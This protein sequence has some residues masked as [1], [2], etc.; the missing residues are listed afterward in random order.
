MTSSPPVDLQ[1]VAEQRKRARPTLSL[2]GRAL[3]F[4]ARREHSRAE[5]RR[6]LLVDDVSAA[7][8]DAVLDDLEAKRLLSDRRYA[9]VIAH[10]RGARYGVASLARTLSMQGVDRKV[11]AEALAPLRANERDRALEIWKRRFG[12][13]P[14]NLKERARQHRFLLGRGFDPATVVW[15]LKQTGSIHT[16]R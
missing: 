7:A 4:L 11:A 2:K 10:A 1:E 15:V 5:L 6:K 16:G 9:E 8:V 3:R 13:S 12:D 14:V